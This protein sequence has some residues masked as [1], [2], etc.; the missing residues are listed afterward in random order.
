M[1]NP[2][3]YSQIWIDGLFRY[4]VA[5]AFINTGI[6]ATIG[7][8]R[9]TV[10]TMDTSGILAKQTIYVTVAG[11][12]PA[13][14]Q[15]TADPSVTICIPANNAIVTSPVT[16]AASARDSAAAVVNMFIWVDGVKKWIGSGSS[17]NTALPMAVG[18]RRVTVQ[19]KDALGRYFQSAVSIKVQ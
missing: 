8:H 7:T 2:V 17:V 13:C 14:T 10:Q 4:Q 12:Q 3:N 18:T 1:P 11:G 9:L 19:A 6:T 15:N 5:S 16:I